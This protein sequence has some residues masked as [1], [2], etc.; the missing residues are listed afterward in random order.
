MKIVGR[1]LHGFSVN[2]KPMWERACSRRR[3]HIQHLCRLI[4]RFREQARSHSFDRI[5]PDRMRKT[6]GS[7][8]ASDDGCTFNLNADWPTA[9]AGKPAPT[10]SVSSHTLY[11]SN[12][13][14]RYTRLTTSAESLP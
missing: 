5:P 1:D 9:I 12:P 3:L 6:C 4:H 10:G 11:F 13:A 8:L 7:W 2:E 14:K